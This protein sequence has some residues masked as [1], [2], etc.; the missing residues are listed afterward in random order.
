MNSN[1]KFENDIMA[2]LN[3]EISAPY[4]NIYWST[5]REGFK[6]Q[7]LCSHLVFP[8]NKYD[9]IEIRSPENCYLTQKYDLYSEHSLDEHI[10]CI[11]KYRL[12]KAIVIAENIDFIKQCPSLRYLQISPAASAVDFDY[13]PLYN[14]SEFLWLSCDTVYGTDKNIATIDYSKIKGLK[15]LDI[16]GKGHFNY[17]E[18]ATLERLC[19]SKDNEHCDLNHITGNTKLKDIIL[20]LCSLTSLNGI[21][22]LKE[23]QSI[24]LAYNRKLSD[25]SQ[26][27]TLTSLKSLWIEK[28]AKITDFSFL[29]ELTKLEHLGLIGSNKLDNLNFLKKMKKLKTLSLSMR[30]ADNDLTP[31]L[32]IPHVD[33]YKGYKGYNLKNKDLP[34]IIIH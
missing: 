20:T 34:K 33:L 3:E 23:L 27:S 7:A 32:D 21:S 22:E 6:F 13:S 10:E 31:C 12:E 11:N 17:G 9:A 28:C 15:E 2:G 25:I 16:E 8:C 19:V 26:I 18:I 14:S 30:V 5:F 1:T 29:E 4:N 24:G